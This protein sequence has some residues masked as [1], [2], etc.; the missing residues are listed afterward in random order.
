MILL[1]AALVILILACIAV[2]IPE[3]CGP[4]LYVL[5]YHRIAED[6]LHMPEDLLY[7][8]NHKDFSSQMKWLASGGVEV[9]GLSEI[10]AYFYGKR[11]LE[12]RTV[13]VTFDDGFK[14]LVK[15]GLP[16]IKK[17]RI[18]AILF[19]SPKPY[20]HLFA[21]EAD[22]LL[23]LSELR[24]LSKNGV[25]VQSHTLTHRPLPELS[26]RQVIE[27]LQGSKAMLESATGKKVTALGVPGNFYR[28]RLNTF[29]KNLGYL[30]CFSADKGS[31][32][33]FDRN[34]FHIRRIVVERNVD[35]NRFK[36]LVSPLPA[37]RA[38][39]LGI[40]KK[41]PLTYFSASKW[42]RIRGRV[43]S[44]P[45]VRRLL[46]AQGLTL[47]LV[48]ALLLIGAGVIASVLV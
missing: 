37:A 18:P 31:N 27:E 41:L 35:L 14:S 32:G 38:R 45:G 4:R 20:K 39:L 48:L 9:W 28:Q 46:T 15:R 21:D 24:R 7:T 19:A 43:F 16:C 8:V 34:P 44:I 17:N 25:S 23:E 30:L 13:A 36:K 1:L 6:S 33:K 22:P 47:L 26:D 42:E 10:L 29:L 5:L 2:I 11:R 40:L 3:F 12:K